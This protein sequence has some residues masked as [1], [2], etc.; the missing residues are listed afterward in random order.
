MRVIGVDAQLPNVRRTTWSVTPDAAAPRARPPPASGRAPRG[1]DHDVEPAV[2]G[3]GV[4]QQR[5]PALQRS[6]V[7]DDDPAGPRRTGGPE[8]RRRVIRI[9]RS[10]RRRSAAPT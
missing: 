9:G 2:V 6:D 8:W 3:L 1:E 5:Q 7:A 10:R 4:G